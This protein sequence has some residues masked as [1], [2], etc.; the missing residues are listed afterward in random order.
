MKQE[1]EYIIK[2][3]ASWNQ[4]VAV[5]LDSDFYDMEGFRAGQTSLNPF[6]LEL[7]GDVSGKKILHLQCHFGQ[8]SIS[9]ARMGASVTGADLSD[10]AVDAAG[11]LAA[12]LRADARFI[13]C[14]L[15]ELPHHL[16][17]T[18]DIV[19]TS[20]GTIGWLPDLD[21]WAAVISRFLKPGGSFIMAD[22]HPVVWMYD[23]DFSQVAYSY[24]N[25]ET[26]RE[27]TS[28][29]YANP[30]AEIKNETLSWNHSLS[31]IFM[32]LIGQGLRI[33]VFREYDHSPYNCFQNM[34]AV[35]K[36]NF[37]LAAFGNK[38]P[39]VYAILATRPAP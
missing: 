37:V 9:L 10:A 17:E 24:F 39:M 36:K 8:D 33:D 32:A 26:I 6:E 5:H 1:D 28:G 29:T 20:Y 38:I 3:R 22:F 21:R 31:E 34:I 27:I 30:D 15:Y 18:F 7:L 4:R 14:D 2:N 11:K 25:R 23:N 12:E 16:D 19:F 35:D 13:C